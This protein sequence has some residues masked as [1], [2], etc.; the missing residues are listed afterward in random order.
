MEL[1]YKRILLKLSGE[2]LAGDNKFG[3]DSDILDYFVSEI[4]KA[5]ESKIQ[6]GIVIGGG[7]IFRGLSKNA[8]YMDRV[9]A[10]QM[11]MLATIINSLAIKDALIKNGVPSKLMSAV[12][13]D[14]FAEIFTKQ[15]A[16]EYLEHGNVVIFGAGTG[17]P[18]F[19]TDTAAVLRAVE[20]ES[21]II[22]KG[23][24]VD[25]VYDSDPETNKSAVK[26]NSLSYKEVLNRSLKVMDSTAITLSMDNNLP[27]NVFN[28]NIKDN[29]LRIVKGENIGTTV[30][31]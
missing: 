11:G 6:L 12:Q 20:I 18:Y 7:N 26:F 25:G 24:R 14:T 28:F 8:V 21:D 30:R 31:G 23:T 15:K 19:T 9:N 4:K 27:I 13:M 22:L 3:I 29:L 17:N 16:I 1:K 2:S 10:D 5:F